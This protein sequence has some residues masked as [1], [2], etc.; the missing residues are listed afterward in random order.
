MPI[1][2]YSTEV[3]SERT[4]GEI[5]GMLVRKGARSIHQEFDENGEVTAVSFVMPVGGVAVRFQL[6][7]R[8]AGVLRVL[9][10][11]K[12][13]NSNYRYPRGE[14]EQRLAAQAKRVSWRILKDWVEAQLALIESGQAEMGQVFM[15]YATQQDGRTMYELWFESNQKQ[16][17][18]GSKEP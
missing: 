13:Y 7:S 6:P 12:P 10:K 17:G 3:P 16:L 8:A 2:N 9:L 1:L 5:T 18:S 14:H 4:I 11:E 15:P